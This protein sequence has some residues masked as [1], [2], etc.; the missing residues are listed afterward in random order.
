VL[1]GLDEAE[2][3]PGDR[4]GERQQGELW[5]REGKR[6]V[7]GSEAGDA[8]TEDRDGAA[9]VAQSASRHACER[10]RGVVADV[11]EEGDRHGAILAVLDAQQVGRPQDEERHGHVADL[12]RRHG[13]ERPAQ[14]SL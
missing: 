3:E 9:P 8:E 13:D 2:R 10:C 4:K 5:P 12:E 11:E 1:R 6:E 7:G 14:A